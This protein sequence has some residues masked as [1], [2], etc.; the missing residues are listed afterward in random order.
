MGVTNRW[1]MVNQ[2]DSDFTIRLANGAH[3]AN[4]SRQGRSCGPTLNPEATKRER[5]ANDDSF[6]ALFAVPP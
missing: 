1:L 2:V 6:A 4:L 3:V 5:A